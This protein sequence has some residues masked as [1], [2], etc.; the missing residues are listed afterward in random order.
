MEVQSGSEDENAYVIDK[1]LAREVRTVKAWNK[2][3]AHKET[4]FLTNGS[5]FLEDE[6][7]DME[8]K[9][10]NEAKLVD[11]DGETAKKDATDAASDG[12]S[13]DTAGNVDANEEQDKSKPRPTT[14]EEDKRLAQEEERFLVKWKNISHLHCSWEKEQLLL[15]VDKNAKGKIQRFREKQLMGMYYENMEAGDEYFSPEFCIVDRILDI[16]DRPGDNFGPSDE[17]FVKKFRY[18]LVKWKGL[19]YDQLTWEREDDV[20]DD[21]AVRLYDERL[22]SAAKRYKQINSSKNSQS[23]KK[24]RRMNF[25]GYSTTNPPPFKKEQQFVLREYQLTGVNWMLFNWYQGRNSMLADEMGLG[26]T[27]QTV[28]FINHLAV[29]EHLPGP[30]L[31]IA[32]LSTLAHWQREFTNWTNLNAIVY[33][34]S[35]TARCEIQKYE[36]FITE[37]ELARSDKLTG[38]K[39][40]SSH[41]SKKLVN[42]YRFDVMITTPEMCC[43]AD[44]SVLARLK[45]QVAV[46]DEAHRL[47][48][49]SS[50][51]SNI[52]HTKFSY[53]NLL[54]LTGTPLQNNVEELWTLLNFLDQDRFDS[55]QDF[56]DSY[57]ELKDSSQV[58]RLHT[59]LKPFLLRRM[60]EDV[61]TSLAPKEETI[62]EVELTVLQ[63]QYYRAIYEQNTEFLS[64]MYACVL[65]IVSTANS[66]L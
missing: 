12:K 11:A 50:K 16:Q 3:C 47:K 6:D 65:P 30:Y 59:E 46:V 40:T 53:E 32:P 41:R 18:F 10:P 23:R 26:K 31:V 60:K 57:G 58:E 45:W 39:N 4:R 27:V 8:Q 29:Q 44:F 20:H 17:D 37:E 62:I 42:S 19:P 64:V 5:I 43:A 63:K 22:I 15:E 55:M 34:G 52:L 66:V 61:E 48:N 21:D 54:L 51:M 2:L 25:K 35:A 7:D 13:T 1:V 36:F 24:N 28:T 33:H 49:R 56:L 9:K 14:P 38:T